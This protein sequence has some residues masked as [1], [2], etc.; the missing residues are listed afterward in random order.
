[1]TESAQSTDT[2]KDVDQD[3]H[4][5]QTQ[6]NCDVPVWHVRVAILGAGFS[7]LGMAIQL[8]RHGYHD[9]AIIEQMADVGGTWRDNTYPGCACDT[10]SHLYS[11][12]FAPNPNWSHTFA[13]Q[14][15]IWDYLRHCSTRFGIGPH[16]QWNCKL[17]EAS[18]HNDEQH[19]H[20]KTT[21]GQLTANF[22][23]LGG[24]LLNEPSLPSLPGIE[25][26]EGTLFHSAR[27][28]HDYD[29]TGKRVAVI[30][31]GA[32]TIQF[33][34]QIQPLVG[35]LSLFQRTP[36][37]IMPHPSR[38]IPAWQ[39]T[40][41]RILPFTQR[42]ARIK[43]Y[44]LR[45]LLALAFVYRTQ[46]V[47]SIEQMAIQHLHNQINDPILREKLT[48]RYMLGCKRV[49]ISN[50]FYPAIARSNV[51]LVTEAIRE[52][53]TH[54][55]VTEDGQERE[56]DTIICATGFHVIENQLSRSI[57]GRDGQ[58]LA[59]NW[60]SCPGAYLGI[61]VASFPN[62][63]LLLGPNTALGHTSVMF[64]VEAQITY[65]LD[66]LRIVDQRNLGAVEVLPASQEMFSAEMQRRS[67]RT[68]WNSGCTSWY[69][70]TK[71][72]N[73]A[74]WPGFTF[75][76]WYRTRHF[77]PQHYS[78]IVRRGIS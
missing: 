67:R 64:M 58:S 48:P 54:C 1:M 77:D 55:I 13:N 4:F 47:K 50:N 37:W 51:E 14:Q 2:S 19:W 26:F 23:I 24:G 30:G 75:E 53:Q 60:K 32:S 78:A 36:S 49:P 31:T 44:W 63:F 70:N 74:I 21:Q 9:F 12:S 41:F 20:I 34:P 40:L 11:F 7:G 33:V 39:K 15:E 71:G 17:L 22:F 59:D 18:W 3:V 61:T 69:L 10:P 38:P 62:L 42:L 27:W 35:Q 29:L 25:N 73:T 45:E 8:K 57:Y 46:L 43:A 72:H 56:I 52:V 66:C 5:A 76:F 6:L 65:I 28:K 68:V 16:I